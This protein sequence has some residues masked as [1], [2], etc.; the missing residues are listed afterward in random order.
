M[1]RII[2]GSLLLFFF[3]LSS[4]AWLS[5]RNNFNTSEDEAAF[6]ICLIFSGL[7]ALLIYLGRRHRKRHGAFPAGR[8]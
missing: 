5:G 1:V 3:G 7:G 8:D 2:L 6:I 4:L